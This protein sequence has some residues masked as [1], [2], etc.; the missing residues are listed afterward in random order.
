LVAQAEIAL[1]YSHIAYEL[2]AN[3]IADILIAEITLSVSVLIF[4]C[5]SSASFCSSILSLST[6]ALS[7][8]VCLLSISC[9]FQILSNSNSFSCAE[10]I[11]ETF[12][13][14]MSSAVLVLALSFVLIVS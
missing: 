11:A 4:I 6:L 14:A 5:F 9:C 13:L 12:A 1:L 10:L 8:C 3:H 7:I 2:N